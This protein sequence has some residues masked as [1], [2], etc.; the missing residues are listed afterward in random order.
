MQDLE[1]HEEYMKKWFRLML[2]A[3]LSMFLYG[4]AGTAEKQGNDAVTGIVVQKDGKIIH[5]IYED[6][7]ENYYSV[8]ELNDMI[9]QTI[10]QYQKK[11]PGASITLEQCELLDGQVVRVKMTYDNCDTYSQFNG[12]NLFVGTVQ[13]AYERGLTLDFYLSSVSGKEKSTITKKELLNMGEHHIV[14]SDEEMELELETN[15]LFATD[16][17]RILG[18]KKVMMEQTHGMNAIVFK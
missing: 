14:I 4:C 3:C 1:R 9:E 5:T 18:K 6:F 15:I 16:T 11:N 7:R 2:V 12:C 17:A 8:E 10:Q 13:Q